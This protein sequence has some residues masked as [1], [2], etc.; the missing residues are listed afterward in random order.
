MFSADCDQALHHRQQHEA[1]AE[2]APF[3][4]RQSRACENESVADATAREER[5]AVRI[6]AIH[7]RRGRR[8]ARHLALDHRESRERKR[9]ACV[10]ALQRPIEIVPSRHAERIL[11]ALFNLAPRNPRH[12]CAVALVFSGRKHEQHAAVIHK[13]IERLRLRLGGRGALPHDE[14]GILPARA[15]SARGRERLRRA[16]SARR[17]GCRGEAENFSR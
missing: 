2:A 10:R 17:I 11:S 12:S 6:R 13:L 5:L 1:F 7:M 15:R 16:I 14:R 4:F 8:R 9:H 3:F